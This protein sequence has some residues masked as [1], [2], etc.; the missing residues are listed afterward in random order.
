M[1]RQLLP[2][3]E[4]FGATRA[5]LVADAFVHGLLC[6]LVPALSELG[7]CEFGGECTEEEVARTA[8]Y[9]LAQGCDLVIG[10]GGGKAIDTAK[11]AQIALGCPIFI[12]PTVAATDAPTS[13]VVVLYTAEHA[14]AGTQ[15]MRANPDVVLV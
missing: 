4:E 6:E 5:V 14:L 1:V 9:C 12:V 10:C 7:W 2:T 13:R 3:V 8:E 15:A 11:G